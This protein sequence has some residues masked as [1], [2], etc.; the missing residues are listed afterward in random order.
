MRI[1]QLI[2]VVFCG[3]SGRR[4]LWL[5]RV[6]NSPLLAGGY[7]IDVSVTTVRPVYESDV[8]LSQNVA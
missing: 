6:S 5:P 8:Y 2:S 1:L 4:I 7:W 3:A